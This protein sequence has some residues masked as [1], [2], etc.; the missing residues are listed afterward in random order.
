MSSA[1]TPSNQQHHRV[2]GLTTL[3][4]LGQDVR[5]AFSGHPQA[6]SNASGSGPASS[7]YAERLRSGNQIRILHIRPSP[8]PSRRLECELKLI[9][10]DDAP[11]YEALSYVWGIDPPSI[12]IICNSQRLKI[13]PEISYALVRLRLKHI[14]R[15]IW[16]DALCIN[17]DDNQEKSHQVPL[18]RKIYSQAARVNVWLGH[19]D[20]SVIREAFR[21]CK[22][23][24]KAC[25]EFSLEHDMDL[26][27]YETLELVDIPIAIFTP[28]ACRGLEIL[29]TRPLFSR[30]WC[31]Q[32]VKLAKDALVVWGEQYLPWTDVGLTASVAATKKL[33][34]NE[35]EKNLLEEIYLTN[36]E[37]IHNLNPSRW[38]LLET[39]SRFRCFQSTD[40]RDKVYGLIGLVGS[41]ADGGSMVPDYEKSVARV[42]TETALHTFTSTKHLLVF[43]DVCHQANYDGDDEYPSWAPRWDRPGGIAH[44]GYPYVIP[45]YGAC[46][47]REAQIVVTESPGG[48]Q[49]CLTGILH[50]KVTA[51][52]SIFDMSHDS[53]SNGL[54]MYHQVVELYEGIDWS[55]PM[56]DVNLPMLA[57]TLTTGLST[58]SQILNLLDEKSRCAHYETFIHYIEWYRTPTVDFDNLRGDAR[59]YHRAFGACSW[60]RRFFWTSRK[61]YGMGPACMREGDIVVV[62]YGGGAPCVLRPKG[63]KYLMLGEAYVDS[64]MN[65]ELVREVEEGKRQE[66]EFCLI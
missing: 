16:A 30:V 1:T 57:R 64:I 12:T 48:E 45:G 5:S 10:L 60:N 39:L 66:Q 34:G 14:T 31:I 15:I 19:G 3:R 50:A 20:E 25:R 56:S 11:V 52:D 29:A 43:S 17:Q 53:K 6:T 62:F 63:D 24:A 65:G 18:M 54:H 13:R 49:L 4:R 41:E 27:K 8:K 44:I 37:I 58:K 59:E 28:T 23:V 38:S 40:P 26:N 46:S 7:I 33:R 2:R 21:C 9:N 51:I 32:E 42:F 55:A 61:D 36:I 22:L 47:G 35:A